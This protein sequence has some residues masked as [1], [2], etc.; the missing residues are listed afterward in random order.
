MLVRARGVT[1][2]R[3]ESPEGELCRNGSW[4]K[5]GGDPRHWGRCDLRNQTL[6]ALDLGR[7]EVLT[8]LGG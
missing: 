8:A 4:S 6:A 1:V 5:P 3:L 7:R 2:E